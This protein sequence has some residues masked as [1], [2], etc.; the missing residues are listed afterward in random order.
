M[1]VLEHVYTVALCDYPEL[2]D[3]ERIAAE[4]RYARVL[5]RQCGGPD[6]VVSVLRTLHHLED[7]S[8][9]ALSPDELAHVKLWAK[10]AGAARTAAYQGLGESETAYFDVRISA[11]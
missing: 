4:T 8:P 2:P 1:E 9:E 6:G 5:E 3:R 10:A 11:H 7:S